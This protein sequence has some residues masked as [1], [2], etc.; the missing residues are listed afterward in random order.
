LLGAG[1]DAYDT[2]TKT[3][4]EWIFDNN[5]EQ[6]RP[7]TFL[8]LVKLERMLRIFDAC[9]DKLPNSAKELKEWFKNG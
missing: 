1:C 5:E 4:M 7:F 3:N 8:E 2:L 6:T 9:N